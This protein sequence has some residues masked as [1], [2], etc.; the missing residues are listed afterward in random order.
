MNTAKNTAVETP[1]PENDTSGLY[2]LILRKLHEETVAQCDYLYET[3]EE[4]QLAF[5]HAELVD[6]M[7]RTKVEPEWML[8]LLMT[9][10]PDFYR[11]SKFELI[12]LD[13][14]SK[15]FPGKDA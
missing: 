11:V 5:A 1:Q 9:V 4:A 2:A 3:P 7:R 12:A 10:A 8:D 6:F 13:V 14:L 15:L